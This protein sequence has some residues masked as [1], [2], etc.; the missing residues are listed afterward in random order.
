MIPRQ[1]KYITTA[2][3]ITF[4][5]FMQAG[6]NGKIFK[7]LLEKDNTLMYIALSAPL[8][9]DTGV[10][11]GYSVAI[12]Q[13]VIND[14]NKSALSFTF[15]GAETGTVVSAISSTLHLLGSRV[16]QIAEPANDSGDAAEYNHG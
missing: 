4:A 8:V 13:T 15:T 7:T 6:C 5:A 14:A 10:P 1:L 16:R 11:S 9:N 12:D 3:I 2:L